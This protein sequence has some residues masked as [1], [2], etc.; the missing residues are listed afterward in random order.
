MSVE[1]QIPAASFQ[2]LVERLDLL[3][4]LKIKAH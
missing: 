3:L 1:Q 2:N 4:W